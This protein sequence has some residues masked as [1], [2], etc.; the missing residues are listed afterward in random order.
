MCI[1][2]SV[3]GVFNATDTISIQEAAPGTTN[4]HVITYLPDIAMTGITT[5]S[6]M[7][8]CRIFR[9]GT[10]SD[11][12]PD[13]AFLHEIDFHFKSDKVLGTIGKNN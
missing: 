4:S 7:L 9:L 13:E 12:Y 10:G 11:T 8:I 1:R 2:D 5:P 3:G 6:A